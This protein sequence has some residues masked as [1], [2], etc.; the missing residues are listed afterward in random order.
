M[1]LMTAS[2]SFLFATGG[3]ANAHAKDSEGLGF[4]LWYL[5]PS[6]S[7][8]DA[9]N[10]GSTR[11]EA[12]SFGQEDFTSLQQVTGANTRVQRGRPAYHGSLFPVGGA[13]GMCTV[14]HFRDRILEA[15]MFR[16]ST[17]AENLD[18]RWMVVLFATL[19]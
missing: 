14:G 2:G 11:K 4:G 19:P 10:S 7:K 16:A 8:L 17:T 6:T 15:G 5:P 18:C 13:V 12:D 3:H 9:A 1:R